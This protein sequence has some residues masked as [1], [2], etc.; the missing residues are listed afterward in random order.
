MTGKPAD[1][2]ASRRAVDVCALRADGTP[3]Q[4]IQVMGTPDIAATGPT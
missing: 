1:P 2:A 4:V 3:L